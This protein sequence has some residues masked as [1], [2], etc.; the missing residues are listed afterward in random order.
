MARRISLL[1]ALLCLPLV[2]TSCKIN[3][4]NSFPTTYAHIRFV[5]T[6]TDAPALDVTESGATMWSNVAFQAGTGSKDFLP[7]NTSFAVNLTGTATTLVSGNYALFGDQPYTLL[8]YGLQ[9][10]PSLLMI[11]DDT[12]TPNAGNFNLRVSN[13]AVSVGPVD[14]YL[15]K[16]DDVLDNLT[17]NFIGVVYGTATISYR[18]NTNQ[19]YRMRVTPYATKTVIYDSGT[20]TFADQSLVDAFVYGKSS[21]TLVNVLLARVNG[22]GQVGPLDSQLANVRSVHVAPQTG[23]IN[24]LDNGVAQVSGE[25]YP[26]SSAYG[27]IV[28]ATR[29]FSFE[30]ATAPG[31]ILARLAVPIGAATD[32]TM[33]LVGLPG[34]L[35]AIALPDN[36]VLSTTSTFARVRFVNVSP[37]TPPIDVLVST[38][39]LVSAV[40]RNAASPYVEIA[41]GTYTLTFNDATTGTTLYT[42]QNVTFN[43]AT[44][45][46][47]FIVGAASNLATMLI[48]DR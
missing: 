24:L 6:M 4:I 2:L 10:A 37:D 26:S 34:A 17:P 13:T 16:P 18:F 28:P 12:V 38:T 47:V 43:S 27:P 31:T 21:G 5:N 40:A 14:V 22:G 20:V 29:N 19:Q 30:D 48:Q 42:Q 25:I 9:A 45:A 35:A 1:L 23:A 15:T 7:S 3:T 46:S 8:A 44:V 39:K 11:P 33:M 41:T 32:T 36:N